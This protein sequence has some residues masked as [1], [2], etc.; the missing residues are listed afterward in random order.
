MH[1]TKHASTFFCAAKV[2]E[3]LL[4][5][6]S[7]LFFEALDSILTFSPT[8]YQPSEAFRTTGMIDLSTEGKAAHEQA[9]AP[10]ELY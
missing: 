4:C 1:C 9:F 7:S 2:V 10:L 8:V 3:T 5:S 6:N